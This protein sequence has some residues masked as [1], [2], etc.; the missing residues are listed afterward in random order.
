MESI[1]YEDSPLAVYLEGTGEADLEEPLSNDKQDVQHDSG[2]SFAPQ[3][4]PHVQSNYRKKI[5]PSL[6]LS[7]PPNKAAAI[8][9]NTYSRAINSRLG[10]TDNARFL[11]RFRYTIVASQ[12]LA[13]QTYFAQSNGVQSKSPKIE[14]PNAPQFATFSATGALATAAIAFTLTWLLNWVRGVD[15]SIF[16][17]GRIFIFTI[18]LG[19]TVAIIY[20]YM[21]RQWLHYLRQQTVSE[22]SAF[23]GIS[24]E[25]DHV[26]AGAMTLVQEVELVSRGYR[27]SNPLPPVTRLEE[28][29]QRKRC[30]RL[31]KALRMCLTVAIP[32]YQ[33][34]VKAVQSMTE[35]LDLEKY[36]DI[37]DLTDIDTSEVA[38]GYTEHE[39]EDLESLRVLKILAA[40]FF[41][42]RKIFL[43]CLLALDASGDKSDFPRWN[44]AVDEIREVNIV[45]EDAERKLREILNEE[46]S[47]HVPPTPRLPMTPNRERNRAQLR[48]LNSLSTG[49]RGLQAKLQLLR[50]E[51]DSSLN[52][53]VDVSELGTTL[54]VQYESIGM[55]LKALMQEWEDGKNI[56]ASNI[57]RHERRISSIS[58]MLSP[59]ISLGGLT[60]VEEGGAFEALRMLNGEARSRSSMDFSSSDAEEVFEAVAMPKQRSLLTREERISKMKEDRSRR[61]LMR[62]KTEANTNMLRELESVINMRPRGRTTA[63]G[64]ITSI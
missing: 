37:Y 53:T 43:C 10:R 31:R 24:Q 3:G 28:G 11:E 32:R 17:K 27:I 60:A 25:F 57:N 35:E 33:K 41:L 6:R 39:F 58:G 9:R 64:R 22:I 42:T 13:S 63:G 44:V 1:V 26:A 34:A 55:D 45:T 29:S 14:T 49:I 62:D 4:Q 51:S 52:D 46:E 5:A 50:E 48:K 54:M 12:L 19:I 40:R 38:I 61:E 23:V 30:A 2:R 36:Y 59:T 56:L 20:A 8:V 18:A 16:G 15:S 7:I 47:F 21:R